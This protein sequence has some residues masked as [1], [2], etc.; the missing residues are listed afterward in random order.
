VTF[1]DNS[2]ATHASGP[3]DR[4]RSCAVAAPEPAARFRVVGYARRGGAAPGAAQQLATFR[5]ALDRAQR[6]RPARW[7]QAGVA[8]DQ[9]LVETRAADG[10]NRH[11]GEPRPKI[12]LEN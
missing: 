1:P 9:I 4:R 11:C 6:R 10:R 5:M 7:L 12:F 2:F 3:P 8:P